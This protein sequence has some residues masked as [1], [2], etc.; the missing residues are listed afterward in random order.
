[1]SG[2]L[3]DQ[4]TKPDDTT[5]RGG[6]GTASRRMWDEA[7]NEPAE[8]FLRRCGKRIRATLVDESYRTAGGGY[9]PPKEISEGIELVHAGSL[10]IDDIEDDSALRRGDPTLHR[11]IG[12]P[13]ALNTGNW[14][15]FRGLERL[16]EAPVGRGVT[17]RIVSQTIR[18]VRRCHEGQALDLASAVDRLDARELRPTAGAISR[19]KTGGLTSLS[20]WIGAAAAGGDRKTRK[21]ICRFGMNVGVCLQMRNDLIELRRFVDGDPRCDDLRNARV[22]WPWVWAHRAMTRTDF[23]VLRARLRPARGDVRQLRSIANRLLDVIGPRGES[24]IERRLA[25]ELQLLGER[26]E[27]TGGLE[28]VVSKLRGQTGEAC[29]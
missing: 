18:T 21:A 14:M 23:Q 13:L 29:R 25:G 10:I 22:T 28:S 19:L 2:S 24:S 27:S 16:S 5:G 4:G 15:Y 26:V 9:D 8:R 7:L 20:A 3:L 12:L 6:V 1:M 17:R 11:E